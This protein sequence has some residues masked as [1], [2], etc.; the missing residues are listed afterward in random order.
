MEFRAGKVTINEWDRLVRTGDFDPAY[1]LLNSPA[2][3]IT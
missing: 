3:R 1:L 2:P